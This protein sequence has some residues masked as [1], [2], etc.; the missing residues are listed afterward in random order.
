MNDLVLALQLA[1]NGADEISQSYQHQVVTLMMF[2]A[3][4][5]RAGQVDGSSLV[6]MLAGPDP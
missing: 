1:L 5:A 3:A 4:V 2:A 6:S